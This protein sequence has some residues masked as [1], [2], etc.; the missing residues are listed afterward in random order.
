MNVLMS[1]SEK[2]LVF[3]V[4]CD[5]WWLSIGQPVAGIGHQLDHA[6]KFPMVHVNRANSELF[7]IIF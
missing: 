4:G 2:Y 7:P 1:R 6:E 5:D 3:G